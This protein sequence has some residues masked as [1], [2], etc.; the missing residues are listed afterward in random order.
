MQRTI[1]S[2]LLFTASLSGI[3][4][5]DVP[6]DPQL[7]LNTTGKTLIKQ[8]LTNRFNTSF[9]IISSKGTVIVADPAFMPQGTPADLVA[10]THPH[11]DHYDDAFWRSP[12]TKSAVK[13]NMKPVQERQVKDV[14]VIGIA[15]THRG[16]VIDKEVPDN[17]IYLYEVD[18]LRIAH[19]GDIG[20]EALTA[21]QLAQLGKVDVAIMQFNNGFSRYS[22]EN[23]KGFK[24]MEQ[25]KPQVV[26]ST[27]SNAAADSKMV[28]L[29]GA[30]RNIPGGVLAIS[31]DELASTGRFFLDLRA[32]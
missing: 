17:V 16:D 28:E 19:M 8:V 32:K 14:K 2:V 6:A 15:S 29:M 10:A 13:F 18:G 26:I 3:A 4:A 21:E 23:G 27:H 1:L 24:L 12:E 11:F 31:K 25:L 30:R 7:A 9:V 20:Q 22:V 5:N